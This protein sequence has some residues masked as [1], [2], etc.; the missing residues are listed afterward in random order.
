MVDSA[1]FALDSR[2]R[3]KSQGL[4]LLCLTARIQ[5]ASNRIEDV[6]KES[7]GRYSRIQILVSMPSPLGFGNSLQPTVFYL[8][9][10]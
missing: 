7:H 10:L 3:S 4:E 5:G 6:P 2:I 9:S 8:L 1:S